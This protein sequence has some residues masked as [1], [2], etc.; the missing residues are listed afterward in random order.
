MQVQLRRR[1]TFRRSTAMARLMQSAGRFRGARKAPRKVFAT[2]PRR[3]PKENRKDDA[4]SPSSS[5]D[6]AVGGNDDDDDVIMIDS[7]VVVGQGS[8]QTSPGHVMQ[9]RPGGKTRETA[10]C[11]D[12]YEYDEGACIRL[13]FST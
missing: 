1:H 6:D 5:R 2:D 3:P 7:D 8:G 13:T 9:D 12:D 10:L 11:V 4:P